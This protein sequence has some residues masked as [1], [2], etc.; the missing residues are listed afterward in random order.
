MKNDTAYIAVA[1]NEDSLDGY[2]RLW[3]YK[4][5]H[6]LSEK[7]VFLQEWYIRD[8]RY[9]FH[10][11]SIILYSENRIIITFLWRVFFYLD[12]DLELELLYKDPDPQSPWIWVWPI[13]SL[14]KTPFC[15]HAYS[16][17]SKGTTLYVAIETFDNISIWRGMRYGNSYNWSQNPEFSYEYYYLHNASPVIIDGNYLV[18]CTPDEVWYTKRDWRGCWMDAEIIGYSPYIKAYSQACL[19]KRTVN[20]L[21]HVVWTEGGY[22]PPYWIR[23]ANVKLPIWCVPFDKATGP[24]NAELLT[25]DAGTDNIHMVF[26]TGSTIAYTKSTDEGETWDD[27]IE[28][29]SGVN[30]SIVLD[31]AGLP[32][33]TYLKNDTV[34]CQILKPD[35]SW[36]TIVIFG[37]NESWKPEQPAVAPS[38][39]PELTDY[40]YCIFSANDPTSF[41]SK[42][43]LSIFG[44]N[45]D[46]A[47]PPNEV[48]SGESLASPSIAIT[49]GDYLHIVWE[50]NGEIYYRTSRHPISLGQEIEWSEIYNIS[51]TPDVISEH[52]VIEAFGE[53]IIVAWKEGEPGEIFRRTRKLPN[54]S[55]VWGERENISQ[56]PN[57]ESDYPFLSTPDVVAWQ[58]QIDSLNYEIY[59]WIQGDMVNLS[60]TENAS[61]YPHIAVEPLKATDDGAGAIT[62]DS[63]ITINAIWT[64]AI[65]SESLYEVRFR[66]YEHNPTSDDKAT[67]YIDVAIGDST[68]SPYCEN[69]SGF[70][71]YGEFSCDYS[72][73]PLVYNLPY[74]NPNSNYVLRA[75]VYKEGSSN[76]REEMYVD[77]TFI[78]EVVYTPYV[79]ETVY[80]LLPKETYENDLA[81]NK[82][83]ERILGSYAL[84]ADLKIYEVSLAGSTGGGGA[85]GNRGDIKRYAL[86]QNRPNPFKDLTKIAFAIPSECKVSLFVYDVSG[87]R[88][89]TLI[90]GKMQPGNYNLKWDGKDNQNRKLA[91]GIYFYRLQTEDFKA[92]KKMVLLK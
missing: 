37:Y 91:Q 21:L 41:N 33:I 50:D 84:L 51:E 53:N 86:Y 5:H 34:F 27:V 1:D 66:R 32:R 20:Q 73:S 46:I 11:P 55:I 71:D 56:S 9:A 92:T 3:C 64:E 39:P 59:A 63:K 79:P 72:S 2:C 35:S 40:S 24:N 76:W 17:A 52:P 69:R 75:V 6:S 60:E 57:Q 70:I 25:V 90:D 83:I 85:Q 87:R 36:D 47:P 14:P 13:P 54:D 8:P 26:N 12:Y 74:F 81:I 18:W 67:E 29:D 88:V 48:A 43:N 16:L 38:Y 80:V 82:E 45:S 7:F 42:V 44:I 22:A 23:S 65:A 68:P 61:R 4:Y 89:R 77:T 49:P 28:V 30:P 19:G 15:Y 31:S 62:I 58:E 10:L 78:T